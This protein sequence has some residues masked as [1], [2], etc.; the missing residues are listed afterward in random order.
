MRVFGST[1]FG[2]ILFRASFNARSPFGSSRIPFGHAADVAI[3]SLRRGGLSLLL[4]TPVARLVASGVLLGIR[5]EPKYALYA[6]GVLVLFGLAVGAGY[7][8]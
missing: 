8:H 1:A 2:A 7:A 3:D 5:G 6:G 4:I